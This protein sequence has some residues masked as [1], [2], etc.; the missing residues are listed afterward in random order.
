MAIVLL[1]R[2]VPR[3]MCG[4]VIPTSARDTSTVEFI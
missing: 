3:L 4:R 1:G 2:F